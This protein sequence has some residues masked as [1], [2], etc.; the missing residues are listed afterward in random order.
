VTRVAAG[1]HGPRR[2]VSG[3]DGNLWVTETASP[4]I[5]RLSPAGEVTRF[6]DPLIVSPAAILSGPDG[7][8]WFTNYGDGTPAVVRITPTGTIS[9]LVGPQ[10]FV[11]TNMIVGPDGN[12]WLADSYQVRRVTP[13][14]SLTSFPLGAGLTGDTNLAPGP[15]GNVW[16][17]NDA[18]N[19]VGRITP[20]GAV[21]TFTD[22]TVRFPR[23]L[24]AG[25]NGSMY[26]ANLATSSLG[27]IVAVPDDPPSVAGTVH[28]GSGS[29]VPGIVVSLLE[30]WPSWRVVATGITGPDGRFVVAPPTHGTYRLRFFDPTGAHARQ[31]WSSDT[32]YREATPIPLTRVAPTVE[33]DAVLPESAG[34]I[35]G[36][37]QSADGPLGG[38]HVRVY[39]EGRGYV[40]GAVSG[41]DGYYELR[42]LAAGRYL[43]QFVDPTRVHPQQWFSRARVPWNATVVEVTAGRSWASKLLD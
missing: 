4:A 16:F 2:I 33:V 6:V 28:G 7:T 41:P 18:S 11:T 22:E 42:G 24:V 39:E 26:F 37:A 12:V 21:V 1:L 3:P 17:V 13:T 43:V 38:I 14:G 40:G 30:E 36:R 31:W 19:V 15:D 35:V 23:H 34:S 9:Q 25:A 5:V 29:P 20:A 27:S 10:S 8:V 32:T